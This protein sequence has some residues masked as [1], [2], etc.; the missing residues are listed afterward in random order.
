MDEGSVLG[1]EI[2]TVKSRNIHLN[3][4]GDVFGI[5]VKIGEINSCLVHLQLIFR[6]DVNCKFFSH[7]VAG[8]I[9]N[10]ASLLGDKLADFGDFNLEKGLIDIPSSA[11]I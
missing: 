11:E 4:D 10:D 8:I 6:L 5:P 9:K 2:Q 7:K 1:R 3:F